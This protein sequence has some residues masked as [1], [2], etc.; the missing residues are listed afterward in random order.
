MR[1]DRQSFTGKVSSRRCG[2]SSAGAG[3]AAPIS[4]AEFAGVRVSAQFVK[5]C[6]PVRARPH[7]SGRMGG[8]GRGSPPTEIVNRLN[9]V[10][11][12]GAN[13]SEILPKFKQSDIE[14]EC[15]SILDHEVEEKA[16]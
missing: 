6:M 15:R 2:L 4:E 7:V 16:W 8:E 9:E 12:R 11:N 1:T 10:L 3:G 14:V 5:T 13:S